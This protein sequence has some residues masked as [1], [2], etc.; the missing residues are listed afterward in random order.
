MKKKCRDCGE[1]KPLDEFHNDKRSKDGKQPY[2]KACHHARSAVWNKA[3]PERAAENRRRGNLK[4]KYGMTL[5]EYDEMLE[6][7]GGCC[8]SCGSPEPGGSGTFHVDHCH[9]SGEIRGLLCSNC[10]RGLGYLGDDLDGVMNI[11]YYLLQRDMHGV[12]VPEPD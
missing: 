9:D 7:Q 11:V 6:S 5:E 12:Q 2:C 3:N 10:N 1:E 4:R 8:A